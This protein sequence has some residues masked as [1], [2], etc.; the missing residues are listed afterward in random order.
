M[1]IWQ[2]QDWPRFHWQEA[3]IKP[4]LDV[5]RLLQGRLLG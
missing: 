2:Q 5:V 1:Y 4:H 3:R